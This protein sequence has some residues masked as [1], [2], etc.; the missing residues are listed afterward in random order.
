MDENRPILFA[1]ILQHLEAEG[2]ELVSNIVYDEFASQFGPDQVTELEIAQATINEKIQLDGVSGETAL[3]RL[4]KGYQQRTATKSQPIAPPKLL[5]VLPPSSTTTHSFGTPLPGKTTK[6]QQ[7]SRGGRRSSLLVS[8]SDRSEIP[9]EP[10][11]PR[12][13]PSY[14]QMPEINGLSRDENGVVLGGSP[15]TLLRW[16]CQCAWMKYQ[17]D[18]SGRTGEGYNEG[19]VSI[20]QCE[21]DL[22][23]YL[24]TFTDFTTPEEVVSGLETIL[25]QYPDEVWG[26]QQFLVRWL[27]YDFD[28]LPIRTRRGLIQDIIEVA[29]MCVQVTHQDTNGA[30]IDVTLVSKIRV[31]NALPSAL[32]DLL[33]TAESKLCV[34][35]RGGARTPSHSIGDLN[36]DLLSTPRRTPSHSVSST[37]SPRFDQRGA[38]MGSSPRSSR[39]KLSGSASPRSRSI[40]GNFSSSSTVTVNGAHS[41]NNSVSGGGSLLEIF[42][43]PVQV[44]AEQLTYVD[45]AMFRKIPTLEFL[46]KSW[47]RNRYENVAEYT[48]HFTD[49]WNG[50]IEYLATLVLHGDGPEVRASRLEYLIDLG[51]VLWKEYHNFQSASMINMALEHLSLKTLT[52]TWERVEAK[53][54]NDST[55]PIPPN[56]KNQTIKERL[57][58]V[59]WHENTYSNYRRIE[60]SI[61]LDQSIIPSM[62]VHHKFL[63]DAHESAPH[64]LCPTCKA[65]NMKDSDIC[66]KSRCKAKLDITYRSFGRSRNLADYVKK[67]TRRQKLVYKNITPNREIINMIN[68]GVQ[69]HIMYF[70]M[71]TRAASKLM[72]QAGKALGAT[73]GR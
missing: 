16:A 55:G 54:V 10:L 66:V 22:T 9:E 49:R 60:S 68:K 63:F 30:K 11:E 21:L 51:D 18:H 31:V 73:E 61:P 24:I 34:D 17:F 47:D 46:N 50:M 71:H 62:M 36:S 4:L 6:V 44:I 32:M 69:P 45:A 37:G 64:L 29:L 5:T 1:L 8:P 23:S 27:E 19:G 3:Q 58:A 13:A 67:I 70:D 14:N 33:L 72:L 15:L 48:W 38:M 57:R 52:N 41:N 7:R 25:E 39:K 40:S 59:F 28:Q 12:I 43:Y 53:R 26:L 35:D 20:E 56:A 42:D 2:L 65:F